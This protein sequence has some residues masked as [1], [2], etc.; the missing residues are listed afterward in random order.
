MNGDKNRKQKEARI[1][2]QCK[3]CPWKKELKCSDI[4]NYDRQLHESLSNTIA[5][6]I[7]IFRLSEN[8]NLMACHYS[9]D[10][11]EIECAGW[12][13][14][15]LGSGNNIPLRIRMLYDPCQVIID[16]EQ[17]ESFNETFV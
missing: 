12:M 14:N 7:G 9:K 17:K 11:N 13:H 15:Q 5:K 8:I 3:T 6:D 2:K 4:P 16:G 10:D 1:I